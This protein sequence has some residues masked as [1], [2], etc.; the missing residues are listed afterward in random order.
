MTWTY[1]YRLALRLLPAH[2]RQKHGAAMEALFARELERAREHGPLQS[3][4]VGTAGLWD[5]VRR[6][7]YEQL[8]ESHDADV[9][10]SP[11]RLRRY[12]GSF[13][14]AFVALTGVLLASFATRQLPAM[15]SHAATRGIVAEAILLAVPSIAALT[16]PMSVFVA[17]LWQL[18]RRDARGAL[19]ALAR[20]RNGVRRLAV[21][22]IVGAVGVALLSFVVTAEIVPRSNARLEAV[23]AQGTTTPN[24]RMMTIGELRAAARSVRPS[25]EPMAIAR[26]TRYEVEIQKKLALPAACIV[27]ALAAIAIA[28]SVPRGGA[29]LVIVAS[30]AVFSAYY[31]LIMTGETLADRLVISPFLAMWGPNLLLLGVAMLAVSARRNA[32]ARA[33]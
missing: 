1:L 29:V 13:A 10:H 28:L 12:A 5:A 3:A 19:A 18:T 14:T 9:D 31:V 2:L 6:S 22:V 33:P 27:L 26:A 17:V 15:A 25:A 32:I 30:L 20:E 8:R 24:D 16:I 11:P 23:L 7:A 4:L 21:P